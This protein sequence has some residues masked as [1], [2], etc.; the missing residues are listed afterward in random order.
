MNR[1]IR[2]LTAEGG[3][4]MDLSNRRRLA[5]SSKT[6]LS[7][8]LMIWPGIGPPPFTVGNAWGGGGRSASGMFQPRSFNLGLGPLGGYGYR[9][10]GPFSY[11][12]LGY[13]GFGLGYGRYGLGYGG[14]GYDTGY[15]LGFGYGY[16]SGM[17]YDP[18]YNDG[19]GTGYGPGGGHGADGFG[20]GFDRRYPLYGGV[21]VAPPAA[22][23]PVQVGGPFLGINEEP[24]TDSGGPGMK[25]T[26]VFDGSAAER[27]GLKVGDLI[28]SINGY[29]TK[30]N[31]N[32]TWIIQNAAPNGV[33]NMNVRRSAAAQDAAITATVR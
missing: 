16:G 13:G 32:I 22:T 26:R 33:L 31:G 27:A 4:A 20:L 30:V 6:A 25:V 10:M 17:M 15:G 3:D 24:A 5:I 2:A 9:G 1:G 19:Y 14:L 23:A 29:K 18:Y 8:A 28:R 11:G 12:G 21:V 7:L